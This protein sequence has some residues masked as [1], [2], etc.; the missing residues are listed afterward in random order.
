M[1]GSQEWSSKIWK[2]K[3][4]GSQAVL[5]YLGGNNKLS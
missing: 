1:E 3:N 4:E 2:T 5:V